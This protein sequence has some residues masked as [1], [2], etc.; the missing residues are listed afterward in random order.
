MD[1]PT[2]DQ[3]QQAFFK[4]LAHTNVCVPPFPGLPRLVVIRAYSGTP[5]PRCGPP[6]SIHEGDVIE[7]L[8]ADLHSSWWQVRVT[9]HPRRFITTSVGPMVGKKTRKT[10]PRPSSGGVG[11]GDGGGCV[12]AGCVCVCV[13]YPQ[14]PH[15]ESLLCVRAADWAERHLKVS[16]SYSGRGEYCKNHRSSPRPD[17]PARKLPLTH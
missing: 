8:L 1:A 6:L 3:Q 11:G 7:L 15:F 4:Q 14:H 17:R 9:R 13:L 16:R 12:L 10:N 5:S 2:N